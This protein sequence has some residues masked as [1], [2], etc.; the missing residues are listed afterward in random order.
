MATPSRIETRLS[1]KPGQPGTRKLTTRYGARLVRV[2]Y[3]YD[4]TRRRRLKTIE[5][6]IEDLPWIPAP[7]RIR[8]TSDEIV[9]VRIHWNETLLRSRAL[10][11]G[12]IWRPG[13][14]I[15]EMPWDSAKK[16][17]LSD[18]VEGSLAHQIAQTAS[19][20]G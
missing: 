6:I 10:A 19:L 3:L 17:G 15:W 12:A 13:P 16:L 18:R 9:A 5:L 11:L 1:L 14:E 4:A 7:R 20:G 2:R 8:R